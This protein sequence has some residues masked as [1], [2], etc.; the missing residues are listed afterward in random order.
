MNSIIPTWDVLPNSFCTDGTYIYTVIMGWPGAV[1]KI[2][3]T[4]MTVIARWPGTIYTAYIRDIT[5]LA[6]YLYI[7]CGATS[8]SKVAGVS[9]LNTVV[10]LNPTTM[11]E[12]AHVVA[13]T[14]TQEAYAI[15]NDG[16]NIY[17]AMTTS[18]ST[19]FIVR[20]LTTALATVGNWTKPH[21]GSV[22]SIQYEAGFI[23]V[24][25]RSADNRI[26]KVDPVALTSIERSVTGLVKVL[27][28]FGG[29]VYVSSDSGF[30]KIYKY[31]AATL[32]LAGAPNTW[33]GIASQ[34]IETPTTSDSG[35]KLT[36][37]GVNLYAGVVNQVT[38]VDAA[39]KI[40]VATMTTSAIWVGNA[41][42][43][44]N[45]PVFH[46]SGKLF[47]GARYYNGGGVSSVANG[48]GQ[49]V[50][51]DAATMV[52]DAT[53]ILTAPQP[54][55]IR[56][57]NRVNAI[58]TDSTITTEWSV[59][60]GLSVSRP[61]VRMLN[62]TIAYV[63]V[64]QTGL[65][66]Y[67]I[68]V[69]KSVDNGSTWTLYK[70]FS[71]VFTAHPIMVADSQNNLHVFVPGNN[72]YASDTN[73][74]VP[75]SIDATAADDKGASAV[76]DAN[77][78]LTYVFTTTLNRRIRV[79][80]NHTGLW[81]SKDIANAGTTGRGMY[82]A[83]AVDGQ[84]IIHLTFAGQ[85]HPSINGGSGYLAHVECNAGTWGAIESIYNLDWTGDPMTFILNG[86][87]IAID[88]NDDIHICADMYVQ[89]AVDLV[90]RGKLIYFKRSSGVWSS[91]EVVKDLTYLN[92]SFTYST[93]TLD[94]ANI[95]YIIT[96]VPVLDGNWAGYIESFRK[97]GGVWSALE[98]L[99]DLPYEVAN[100]ASIWANYPR[101]T[102]V[103]KNCIY[104]LSRIQRK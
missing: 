63:V 94:R 91:M 37:D 8:T 40:D 3:P 38:T 74:W 45:G 97:S 13:D 104:P 68:Q 54:N 80:Q 69:Y 78:K 17:V 29:F 47:Y 48:P 84:N 23:Y 90:N 66:S 56:F 100:M 92:G 28:V 65:I 95:P 77:D 30:G 58:T 36:N 33:S 98:N 70:S 32:V 20:K 59:G 44:Q 5:Y 27:T 96:P 75:V 46:D 19:G 93:I 83:L 24:A 18:S 12:V 25:G 10:K 72:T 99:C 7:A 88:D 62:G 52:A 41:N 76:I 67:L 103:W 71:G 34:T 31:D 15:T 9:K 1:L 51:I 64:K 50:K 22:R 89:Y 79:V 101:Q 53:L 16:T 43:L 73:G 81:V 85:N 49:I 35:H 55:Q 82:P 39:V 4:T 14:N 11:S 87:P 60:F 21:A 102:V 6:P 26:Y 42:Q 2:D 86:V 57:S 61:I